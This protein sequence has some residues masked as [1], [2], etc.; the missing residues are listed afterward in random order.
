MTTCVRLGRPEPAG[1]SYLWVALKVLSSFDARGI[2]TMEFSLS[3][4]QQMILESVRRF[5]T[6][7]VQPK[8]YAWD[9][10]GQVDPE[11]FSSLAELGL[12]AMFHPEELGGFG[13]GFDAAVVAM[14]ELARQQGVVAF[15]LG[16]HNGLVC[17]HLAL[18]GSEQQKAQLEGLASEGNK[19]A[20]VGPL[21]GHKELRV[22][23][24]VLSGTAK[25]VPLAEQA[26]HLL[27][28]AEGAEG[29]QAFWFDRQLPGIEFEAM[30][31]LGLRGAGWGKLGFQGVKLPEGAE[32]SGLSA[33]ETLAALEPGL[34]TLLAAMG[35]GIARGALTQARDYAV[36]R[37]QFKKPIGDFQA[38]QWMI[39]DT[40]NQVDAARLLVHRA[41]QSLDQDRASLS[42]ALKA[43]V[44]ASESAVEA[45][46]KAIQI[47]GGNGF[48]REFPV[49]RFARDARYLSLCLGGNEAHRSRIAQELLAAS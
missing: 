48:V 47:H 3:E 28:V 42:E 27:V 45:S 10:A 22:E 12:M 4:D 23:D 25:V 38:I 40:T 49:E 5:A 34:A 44:Y 16:I 18:A 24:G 19:V 14:E 20:W 37:K 26:T 17:R 31:S 13:F 2:E 7:E 35:L 9:Q 1:D 43:L 29:P 32:L 6:T 41:A 36:E 15:L 46:M 21:L 39:A 11:C 30:D 8:A 33:A